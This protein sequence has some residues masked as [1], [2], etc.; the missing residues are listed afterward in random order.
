MDRTCLPVDGLTRRQQG[1]RIRDRLGRDPKR[2]L[3]PWRW[4][5]G[6]GQA[7]EAAETTAGRPRQMAPPVVKGIALAWPEPHSKLDAVVA[8]YDLK[9]LDLI[10][11]RD[12]PLRQAEADREVLEIRGRR[13]H[14]GMSGPIVGEGDRGLLGDGARARL[15]AAVPR[16]PH[17]APKR[18]GRLIRRP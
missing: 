3:D 1:E 13:H 15:D 8:R 6:L 7:L 10:R 2:A 12:D 17:D 14:H 16:R 11:R 18:Q 5:H 9:V 4:P